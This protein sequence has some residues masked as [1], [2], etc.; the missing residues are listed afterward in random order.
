MQQV[1]RL[2]EIPAPAWDALAGTENPFV[3]HA[4]L[5]GLEEHDCLAAHGWLPCHFLVFSGSRLLGALPLY[6]RSNSHGEFVF[7]W[8][9]AEAYEQAGGR[10]YPKLV[11]AIPFTPVTGPRLLVHADVEDPDAMRTLLL[12]SVLEFA[13]ENQLSSWHCLFPDPPAADWLGQSDLLPRHTCQFHWRN[14]GYGDFQDFLDTLSSKPRK[15]IRRERRGV[16]DAGVDVV[17]LS[18]RD[19]TP[20][21]W[22]VFYDFYCTTFARHW[23]NPRLTLPFFRAL[24]EKLP[25]QTLLI[26]AR[27]AGDWIAGAFA[28]IG[29]RTLFGR[30]WGCVKEVPFLHFELCYYQTIEH[31]IQTKLDSV[32]AGVQGEHKLPRGFEP[33]AALSFHWLRDPGFRAAVKRYLVQERAQVQQYVDDL[34]VH[35]PYRRF[36]AG[37]GTH[38]AMD[39]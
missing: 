14:Q 18:A 23:G 20:E 24:G 31:C 10:Y 5:S 17:R 15:Q 2:A 4:F 26:L 22:S 12:Q 21:L 7:D 8:S 35:L 37:S 28:L 39:Q 34:R 27:Q 16:A 32:D 30:H 9:W 6:L 1:Q 38:P 36:G 33:V 29:S 11:S 19:I 3:S 25:E 13:G